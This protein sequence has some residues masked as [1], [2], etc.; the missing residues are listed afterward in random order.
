MK[1]L[2]EFL[3]RWLGIHEDNMVVDQQIK[4]MKADQ[5]TSLS[6][7]HNRIKDLENRVDYNKNQVD[8]NHDAL[9][10]M[11][12][13][14]VDLNPLGEKF[15]EGSWAVVVVNSPKPVV[16]FLDLRGVDPKELELRIKMYEKANTKVDSPFNFFKI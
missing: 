7:A 11:I 9:L 2:V 5:G 12:N 1:K 4:E 16:K 13:V 6:A 15:G 14:G 8:R 10:D 3:R